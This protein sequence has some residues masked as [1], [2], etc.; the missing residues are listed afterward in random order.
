MKTINGKLIGVSLGPGD[1]ELITRKAWKAL[2]SN[3]LWTYPTKV[4]ERDSYALDIAVRG[5]LSV[6][7]DAKAL[8]FPMTM[9]K[10]ILEKAWAKVAREVLEVLHTGR[11]VNFLVL[12]DA[13]TFATFG[14]LARVVGELDNEIII[15]TIAGVPSFAGAAGALNL[16]LAAE[17]DTFAVIPASYG[18]EVIERLL[19]EFDC[20][21]LFK[22]KPIMPELIELLIKYNLINSSYFVERLGAPNERIV[23]NLKSLIGVKVNYL[24][25]VII[26]NPHRS[27]GKLLRGCR[28]KQTPKTK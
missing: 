22:V 26:K 18:I 27:R 15:E 11:D 4:A 21:A 3:A 24:S 23:L 12:G 8:V 28:P 2:N 6:P 9:E 17:D 20:L 25:L 16:Q 13:S 5:G 19:N 1:P 14:H 7:V 10:T